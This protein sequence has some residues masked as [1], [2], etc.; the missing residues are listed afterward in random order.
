MNPFQKFAAISFAAFSFASFDAS[1]AIDNAASVVLLR[2]SCNDG[3]GGTLN[4]CFT[5][6]S[7]LM[8]WIANTRNPKPSD[9]APLTVQVGAGK[10]AGSLGLT[11][12]A[13]AGFTGHISFVGAG[14]EQTIIE[15]GGTTFLTGCTNLGFSDMAMTH[16]VYGYIKW[17]GGGSSTWN[18]INLE[19]TARLWEETCGPTRGTHYWFGSRI[20]VFDTFL[21]AQGYNAA[22]DESWFFGSEISLDSDCYN[23]GEFYVGGINTGGYAVNASNQGEVHVYGS[24]IRVRAACP[25][26]ASVTLRAVNATNG[27]T[28]HVHGTG[29]DVISDDTNNIIA[30]KASGGGT[31]HANASAFN[32]S[33]PSGTVT[34]I[35]NNGGHVHAPYL[36][37]HVPDTDGNPATVDTNFASA[38]GADQTTSTVGTSDGHPHTA[39]YSSTCPA[40]ARWYDTTDKV[41]RSQ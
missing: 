35:S 39:V 41:C 9:S 6:T 27:A 32:L 7:T 16:P 4:N 26:A 40:N 10:F 31:I 24:V 5:D 38:N 28:I 19:G 25:T 21:V 36:W 17:A 29:I 34:R 3:A 13:A 12:N 33:T 37:E 8:S 11:C 20:K 23:N 30:L 1:A 2:T 22:C 18:R 15:N 14:T